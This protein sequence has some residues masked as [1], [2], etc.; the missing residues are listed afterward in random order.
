MDPD[1]SKLTIPLPLTL[2]CSIDEKAWTLWAL[3]RSTVEEIGSCKQYIVTCLFSHSTIFS[4]G[5]INVFRNDVN[6]IV[7]AITINLNLNAITMTMLTMWWT[8]TCCWINVH[9][10]KYTFSNKDTKTFKID[11]NNVAP[12]SKCSGFTI[13]LKRRSCEVPQGASVNLSAGCRDYCL[14]FY[15]TWLHG[16]TSIAI[17]YYTPVLS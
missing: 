9:V 13:N 4:N 15:C 16:T 7:S 11:P 14:C 2:L 1:I 5:R 17:L 12:I 10:G 6:V 3:F 8:A